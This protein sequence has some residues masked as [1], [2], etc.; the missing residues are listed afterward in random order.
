LPEILSPL[1]RNYCVK[2]RGNIKKGEGRRHGKRDGGG[3]ARKEDRMSGEY[4][5]V[6][7]EEESGWNSWPLVYY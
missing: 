6:R 5:F 4:T 3:G 1:G 7:R 2:Y